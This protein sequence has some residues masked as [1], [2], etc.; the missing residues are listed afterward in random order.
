MR[1]CWPEKKTKKISVLTRKRGQ[2]DNKINIKRDQE[3]YESYNLRNSGNKDHKTRESHT[4]KLK[5]IKRTHMM[6][7]TIEEGK[8]SQGDEEMQML[9]LGEDI[10]MTGRGRSIITVRIEGK[11]IQRE[12]GTMMMMIDLKY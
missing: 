11:G 3:K 2:A 1:E 8:K 9:R 12:Q 4:K 5:D 10:R 6:I 7:V